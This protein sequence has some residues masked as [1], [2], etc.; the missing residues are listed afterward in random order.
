MCRRWCNR[1]SVRIPASGIMGAVASSCQSCS[2]PYLTRFQTGLQIHFAFTCILEGGV[3]SDS[4]S[5]RFMDRACLSLRL[6]SC[7]ASGQCQ[8]QSQM[9]INVPN[10]VLAELAAKFGLCQ[11]A[12]N[13][14]ITAMS[15]ATE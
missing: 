1:A 6:R 5:H 12:A 8:Q 3:Y 15:G 2:L 7:C 14:G 9:G 4:D 10:G 11:C 13:H